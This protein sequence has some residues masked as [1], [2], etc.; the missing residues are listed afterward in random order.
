M[1]FFKETYDG[2]IYACLD[3]WIFFYYVG[4]RPI[5]RFPDGGM[6]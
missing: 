5:M 4:I 3:I 6:K 1:Y 2:F